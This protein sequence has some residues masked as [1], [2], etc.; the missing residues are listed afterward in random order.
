MSLPHILC[1][2]QFYSPLI[3]L[4][5]G[6]VR[7]SDFRY[8]FDFLSL[9]LDAFFFT[10]SSEHPNL[11]AILAVGLFGKSFLSKVISL[12]DH[13]C[14]TI[15]FFAIVQILSPSGLLTTVYFN[16]IYTVT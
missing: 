12:F 13:K 4:L 9:I 2:R 8:F 10:V 11:A 5:N 15:F 16:I 3:G 14:L 1:S 6:Y 7:P